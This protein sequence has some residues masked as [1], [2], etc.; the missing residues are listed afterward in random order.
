[1]RTNALA[2]AAIALGF[3]LAA[4]GAPE[5]PESAPAQPPPAAPIDAAAPGQPPAVLPNAAAPVAPSNGM[6]TT[7]VT[8]MNGFSGTMP[9]AGAMMTATDG[10]TSP[11][12]AAT[13]PTELLGTTWQW[14]GT[15]MRG[16]GQVAPD[17]PTHYTLAFAEDGSVAVTADCNAGTGHY[18]AGDPSMSMDTASL[19]KTPCAAGSSST[20]FIDD[21]AAVNSMVTAKRGMLMLTFTRPDG[22]FGGM[23]FEPSAAP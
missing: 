13:G 15:T 20:T 17:D 4:C 10:M 5:A 21:L 2:L 3:A 22:T 23:R 8:A 7:G 6:T 18:T 9:M 14:M 19:P 11:M 1:M 16:G 12:R